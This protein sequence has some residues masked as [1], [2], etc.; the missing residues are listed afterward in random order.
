MAA[1]I[2]AL[3]ASL[4][5][6]GIYALIALGLNFQYGVARILNLSYGDMLI[7][8]AVIA[9]VLVSQQSLS[10][11]LA[12]ALILPMAAIVG[13]GTYRI[14]LMPLVRRAPNR[15]VLE[16]DSLL[17]TF[18]LLFVVQ[19]VMLA[20]VGGGY[21]SYSFLSVPVDILGSKVA[22]NRLLALAIAL[23]VGL[24]LYLLLTRTRIGTAIRALAVDPVSAQLV[25]VD[26]KKLAGLTFALGTVLVALAGVLI[27]TFLT[28]SPT[29]G[30]VFTMKALIIVIM[31]GVGNLPGGIL[32]GFMLGAIESFVAIYGDPQLTLASN[33]ALFLVVLL[34]R[35]NGLFGKASR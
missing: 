17:A 29:M 22:A 31:G 26:V 5:L 34:F 16:A 32:A 23:G 1:L 25:A 2:D 15:D 30:V 24:G 33:Y 27:S 7:A 6:G 13:L 19:G 10:P 3:V 28:F 4:T 8:A 12:M 9:W 35:P 11:F 20:A 14:V 18:G 21:L